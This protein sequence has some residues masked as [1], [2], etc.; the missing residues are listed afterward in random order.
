MDWSGALTDKVGANDT[1]SL[2]GGVYFTIGIGPLCLAGCYVI[3]NPGADV[4]QTVS[5]PQASIRD[6][7]GDGFPDAVTSDADGDLQVAP[8]PIGRTNLLRSVTRPLGATMQ[9][10]YT[11]SGNTYD[12]PQSHFVLSRLVVTDGHPGDGVDTQLTT[13][14][15]EDGL[16]ERFEWE[17]Y[18]FRTVIEEQR[19]PVLNEPLYRST[20]REYADDSYYTK[21]L[22]KRETTRDAAGN[23]FA[24]TVHTYELRNVDTGTAGDPQD[25]SATIFPHLTR[26]ERR[27]YEG[28]AVAAKSTFTTFQYDGLG[29]ITQTLDAGDDGTD[30]DLSTVV[31]YTDCPAT[32]VHQPNSM[33]ATGGDGTLLRK[34]EASIN[35]ATGDVTQVRA[36]LATGL[37]AVT[38]LT[39]Q[40]NGNMLSVTNPAN[41]VGQ[42]YATTYEYD[43]T[44]QTYVTK[45]TDSLGHQSTSGYDF[46]YG[47]GTNNVDANGNATTHVYDGFGRLIE[48]RGPYDQSGPKPTIAFDYHPQAAVPY[49]VSHHLDSFRSATDTVDNV[50]FVDGL[51]REIQTKRDATVYTGDGT[52]PQDRMIVSGHVVYDLAGRAADV[53][54]PT[55]EAVGTAGV[56]NPVPDTV[57]PTHTDYDVLDRPTLERLPDN[58]TSAYAYGFGADRGGVTRQRTTVTDANLIVTQVLRRRSREA[59][60][61]PRDPQWT[62]GVDHFRLRRAR[63][64][65]DCR[66]REQQHHPSRV[67][68][69]GPQGERGESGLR[70]D[71]HHLRPRLERHREGDRDDRG[72]AG[73]GDVRLRLHPAY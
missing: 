52:A 4:S 71:P 72:P 63:P 24:E 37:A 58:S 41:K 2:A 67:R 29:D 47:L 64:A 21:G 19:N 18:G 17:F 23:L 25:R 11:R 35:C 42:R 28:A 14:R 59:G 31:G 8:N 32:R 6:A 53:F 51:G 34:R 56:F 61:T 66:R 12:D 3:I 33:T 54:Y 70:Q 57:A 43:P 15:Y 9:L 60:R 73:Q 26:T 20:V 69:P 40:P 44:V 1:F 7:N 38:D 39:Y 62:A 16:F 10:D 5:R 30:D 36:F 46:K 50:V 55:S 49:A 13:F 68:Q 22:L 48:V 65:S 27:F 45:V